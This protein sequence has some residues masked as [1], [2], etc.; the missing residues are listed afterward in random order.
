MAEIKDV[1]K[2]VT[3]TAIGGQVLSAI[4]FGQQHTVFENSTL[5]EAV[6]DNIIVPFQPS[7]ITAGRQESEPYNPEDDV[8]SIELGY[9]C[10][11]I[12]G[13]RSMVDAEGIPK[14]MPV[15]HKPTDTGLYKL[16][17]FVVRPLD[18]DLTDEQ[19]RRFRLRK[20]IQIDG[21]LYAAYYLRKLDMAQVSSSVI[22]NRVDD[23]VK[24]SSVWTPSINNL[25]PTKP[26]IGY[27][28]D[29]SYITV[30]SNVALTFE[31]QDIEWYLEACELLLGDRNY[32]ITEL[33]YVTAVDKPI[34]R[35][36]PTTGVQTPSTV[37]ANRKLFE[38]QAAQIAYFVCTNLDVT[39]MNKKFTYSVDIGVNEPLFSKNP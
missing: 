32:A 4:Y 21:V 38:V 15:E 35:Q 17:P 20:V 19:R 11:G 31:E 22:M 2:T 10:I 34:V 28:N 7:V 5:Q 13:H 3:R 8:D 12:N 1:A 16:M 24:V 27:D 26:A 25:R 18:N 6:N 37:I 29:A 30:A 36:Y 14:N 33:G 23:G 9:V 39:V